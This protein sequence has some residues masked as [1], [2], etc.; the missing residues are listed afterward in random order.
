VFSLSAAFIF[1]LIGSYFAFR[2]SDPSA[3][4]APISLSALYFSSILC[5]F[6]ST[7]LMNG[8]KFINGSVAGFAFIMLVMLISIFLG[9]G[10]QDFSHG[11]RALLFL[12][13]I[14]AVYLGVFL[15]NIKLQKKR[16]SPYKR[17]K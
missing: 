10:K 3:A 13:I 14:P 5:G 6:L 11:L 1:M 16:K 15:G 8:A 4:I 17:R 12:L 9:T 2:G 7:K